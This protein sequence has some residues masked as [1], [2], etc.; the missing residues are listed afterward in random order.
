MSVYMHRT[1]LS[2]VAGVVFAAWAGFFAMPAA[3]RA[4]TPPAPAVAPLELFLSWSANTYV[5]PD[6]E[7]KPL[8]VSQSRL[9]VSVDAVRN[10]KLAD[11]SGQTVRWYVNDRLINSGR[12]MHTITFPLGTTAPGS[13]DVRVELPD[14]DDELP[15]KTI[16][17]PVTQ[18]YAAIVVPFP[19]RTVRGV[20]AT[21]RAIPYFFNTASADS[22][23]YSWTVNG[24]SPEANEN[25][26]TLALSWTSDRSGSA[27]VSSI[28]RNPRV[29]DEAAQS[30]TD[31]T[32]VP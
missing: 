14:L 6:F 25:P 9:V 4:Q 22:F 8:P 30:V 16:T 11:L 20:T 27:E 13:F 7:G 24:E 32:F 12:G 5:P 28:I 29:Q 18:P 10:G 19:N 21:L 1:L 3:S 26:D 17:I 2:A 31:L 15:S 23:L